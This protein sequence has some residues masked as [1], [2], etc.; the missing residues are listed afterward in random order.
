MTETR[1]ICADMNDVRAAIDVL[2]RRIVELLA[3][4]LHYIDEAARIKVSRDQVR[5][6]AR[7]ADVL[8]KV[9]A[10]AQ[11]LGID[12]AVIEATFEALVEASITHELREFDK[13][14]S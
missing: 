12:E 14:R 13:R 7:I 2:D 11:R 9:R 5:D 3:D 10:E 1:R 8:G 4:R 6:E